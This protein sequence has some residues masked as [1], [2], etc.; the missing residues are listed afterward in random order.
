[1]KNIE[2]LAQDFRNHAYIFD[3][4]L[5]YF[6]QMCDKVRSVF[7]KNCSGCREKGSLGGI[8]IRVADKEFSA[9]NQKKR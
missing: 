3:D 2:F 1:M 6:E 7:W 5:K 4:Q 8:E 9:I